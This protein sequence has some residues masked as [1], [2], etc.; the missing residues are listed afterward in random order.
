MNLERI[1]EAE[2]RKRKAN[3]FRKNRMIL[4]W[5]IHA[6]RAVEVFQAFAREASKDGV[7]LNVKGPEWNPPPGEVGYFSLGSET[8]Y[9][10][11][12]IENTGEGNLIRNKD[13]AEEYTFDFEK[14]AALIIHF[15]P[16]GGVIQVFFEHPITNLEEKRKEP[17]LYRHTCNT[18]D[19]TYSWL[20][21]LIPPFL[22]F[23][24]F[25]SVLERPSIFDSFRVRWWLFFDIR[26]RRGYIEKFQHLFTTWELLVV[27]LVIS[28]ISLIGGFVGL[29]LLKVVSWIWDKI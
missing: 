23:N 8:V 16:A 1:W 25:E 11:F 6:Q 24:R 29:S 14:G 10:G 27:G 21:S 7:R 4:N 22:A 2:S 19:L 12:G 17:I 3:E 15:S 13:G 20:A 18:D 26:N 5:P 9:L 28:V